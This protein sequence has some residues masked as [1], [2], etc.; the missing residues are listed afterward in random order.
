MSLIVPDAGNIQL[1]KLL[2]QAPGASFAD[3][4]LRLFVNDYT[5]GAAT[6]RTDFVEASFPGYYR[7]SLVRADWSTPVIDTGRAVSV[8]DLTATPWTNTGAEVT[9][10]GY[11][12]VDPLTA[13]ALWCERAA[14]PRVLATG[15]SLSM[16]LRFTGKSEFL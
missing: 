2:L 4:S 5:P 16:V 3:W 13:I 12:V 9:V 6:V 7:P 10:Y 14:T 8:F 11:Y 1:C 15:K